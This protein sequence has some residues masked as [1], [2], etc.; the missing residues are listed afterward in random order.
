MAL[1]AWAGASVVSSLACMQMRERITAPQPDSGGCWGTMALDGEG[2]TH[3]DTA[4]VVLR[5]HDV[6]HECHSAAHSIPLF[7][8][9]YFI[10]NTESPG[11]GQETLHA[12]CDVSR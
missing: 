8:S 6:T 10:F 1:R 7:L 11:Q 4:T 5:L 3:A 12:F 9:S 2:H